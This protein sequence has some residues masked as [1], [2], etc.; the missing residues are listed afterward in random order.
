MSTRPLKIG[1]SASL[2]HPD[3]NRKVFGPKTLACFECDMADY[4]YQQDAY[5]ILIPPY[6]DERLEAFM[7]DLDGIVFQGGVDVN[8]MSYQQPYLDQ[9][10][11]PGD[12]IC[13]DY[14]LAIMRYATARKLPVFAICRGAQIVNAFYGGTLYQDLETAGKRKHRDA[15]L[16]D[17]L[18]HDIDFVEGELIASIYQAETRRTIN[19]IHHQGIDNLGE[20][21]VPL[22]YSVED[23]IIEAYRYHDLA[24]H[25]VLAVQW[26]PEFS[27]TLADQVLPADPL[28]HTFLNAVRERT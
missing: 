14:D 2:M 28:Y 21:L 10:K 15:A 19:S 16:Y 24:E 27:H 12:K 3:P 17:R 5:P 11:W 13:D 23:K 7:Q 6:A 25:F 22:A 20:D 8:P 4:L 1:V 9:A 26:H 18:H